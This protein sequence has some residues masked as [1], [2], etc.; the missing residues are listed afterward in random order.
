MDKFD[1]QH[2]RESFTYYPKTGTLIRNKNGKSMDSLDFYGYTQVFYRGK[3]YK[4]HRLIWAIFFGEFP[5][6]QIDHINGVRHDNR[7]ENLRDVNQ[8]QNLHN[9]KLP[10][11]QNKSGYLGVCWNEKSKKWQAGI[12]INRKTKYLGV[13]DN[14]EDAHKAYLEAKKIY[15]VI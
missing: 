1:Y 15:H 7:I 13:F 8:Q 14:K 2:L 9:Q 5:K 11:K 3:T 4:G 10:H 6:G 12:S